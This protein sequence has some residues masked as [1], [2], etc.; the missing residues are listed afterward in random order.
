MCF[1]RESGNHP[2]KPAAQS[3]PVGGVSA[4]RSWLYAPGHNERILSKVF[5]AG[6][7]E[8]VLDLEDAV[9]PNLKE[10][11]RRLVA[12]ILAIH[13][14]WV[15]VNRAMTDLCERDLAAV[16]PFAKG[17]RLAKVESAAEVAWVARL[18]PEVP[19]HCSIE[20]A[21]GVLAAFEIAAAP[22]CLALVYGGAD[23]ALD[24]GI[25]GGDRETLYARSHMVVA[26][27]AAGREPPSD[28]VHT[29]INDDAGLQ[30]EAEAGRRLGF[31]GKSAIHPRQVPIINEA[32]TPTADEI[33]WAKR[34]VVAFEAANG[35]A[36]QLDNGE[37]VDVPVAERALRLLAL[38]DRA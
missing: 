37:F 32:F 29:L 11:A 27:R 17:V 23:L 3:R 1:Q 24:L 25:P 16:V 13:P 26:S 35:A 34:I 6:A 7:D 36:T 5:D 2:S 12:E 31:F 8:I 18:A 9:P 15:R 4:V 20:S 28:G 30:A 10:T 21:R 33:A 19:L 14:A 38:A 22:A